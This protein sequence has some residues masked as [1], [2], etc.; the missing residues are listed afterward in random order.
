MIGP[1]IPSTG[2][3]NIV[4]NSRTAASVSDPRLRAGSAPL[5]LFDA[6][7]DGARPWSLLRVEIV[8][9]ATALRRL[10]QLH[11]VERIALDDH[12]RQSLIA[13]P[14]LNPDQIA[15]SV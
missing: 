9:A 3:A 7:A 5:R 4:W 6:L 10:E 13:G 8:N 11:L 2:G 15:A 12:A 14:P 1:T